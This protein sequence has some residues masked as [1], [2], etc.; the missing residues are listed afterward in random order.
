MT[1][2]VAAINHEAKGKGYRALGYPLYKK[3]GKIEYRCMT[4]DKIFG[5]L[6]NLKVHLRVHT[7]EK[8]F[9]CNICLKDFTQL[10]HLQKHNL[11]HTGE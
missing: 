10:A 3:D 9:I 1:A 4:C 5:Q 11:V 2:A 8:P 6:S 7:G